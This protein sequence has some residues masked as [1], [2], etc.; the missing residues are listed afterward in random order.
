MNFIY[1][2]IAGIIL[3][4]FLNELKKKC[5]IGFSSKSILSK[6]IQ[7]LA[8]QA[9][10]WST[11]AKQDKNSM[12]AVLHANYGAGYLWALKD[13]A[14]SEQI[15]AATGID[16]LK[17]EREIVS[18]Q[19]KATMKMARLCPK[20]APKKSYLTKLGGEG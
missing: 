17:F 14:S 19:D 9:A 8:R 7:V 13:I 4:Y 3:M 12:I 1:G 6:V 10:R 20:Y 18:V 5:L 16:I 2:L 15:K 11:A